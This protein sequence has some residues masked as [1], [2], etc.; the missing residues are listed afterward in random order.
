[1]P[2]VTLRLPVRSV[3]LPATRIRVTTAAALVGTLLAA[4]VAS[5][6]LAAD[7]PDPAVV[8]DLGSRAL[9]GSDVSFD[10]TFDNASASETGYGPYVDLRLPLGA[11]GDDGLTFAGATYLGAPVSAIRL[12]ADGSGC[13]SHPLA[14]DT[15]GQA[16]AVCGM[17][18]GQSFVVLRLPFGSYT[19]DQP[20]ARVVVSAT[21]SPLADLG[22]ALAVE[23]SGGFQFGA[24][25]ITDPATDPSIT[26]PVTTA[27]VTPTVF[28]LT[29][30]Y[31]GPEGE[32][33]TGPNYP[34]RYTI[35]AD[36]AP[37]QVI[38]GL[39]L[40]D[41][42]PG[43]IQFDSFDGSTPASTAVSTPDTAIPGGV[44]T[45]DFATV[46]GGAGIDAELAFGFHVPLRDAGAGAV[47]DPDSGSA[48]TSTDAA[49]ASGTWT[50]LDPRDPQLTVTVGPETHTL[51]DRSIAIQKSVAIAPG[52]DLAPTGVINPGDTLAWT[53][54]LQISDLFAFDGVSVFDRLADGTR[55]DGSFA[56]LLAVD[57]N[58]FDSPSAAFDPANLAVGPVEAGGVTPI[59]FDISAELR[60]R[61]ESGLLIGGCVD[62]AGGSATPDCGSYNDGPTTATITFRSIVQETYVDGT[63]PVV[64]GDDLGNVTSV[65]ASVL[66]TG[67]LTPT[68]DVTGDG[69]T[70]AA[71]PGSSASVSIPRGTLT[72]S[73]YAINGNTAVPSP[74]HLS[75]GDTVTYRLTQTFPNSRTADFQVIDYL[76]LPVLAATEISGF[77]PTTS[78][79]APPAGTAKYGPA[80]T[81]HLLAGA[82]TPVV[83]TSAGA[84][85]VTFTY[86]DYA[87]AAPGAASVADLLLTVTATTDPFSDG[88]SLANLARSITKNSAGQEA[89]SDGIVEI[90]LDQPSLGRTTGKLTKGVVA[91]SRA[92]AVYTPATAAPRTF[93]VPPG[94]SC[95]AWSGGP[96]TSA[97]LSTTP[98]N[99]DVAGLDAGDLAR[100]AFRVEN[101][102]HA[103]AYDAVFRD[104]LPAGFV[105][106]AG[107]IDLCV[108]RGNGVPLSV[109]NVGGGAGL[110]D[111]GI[112]VNGFLGTPAALAGLDADDVL[113]PSG[114]NVIII[115]FTLEVAPTAR[116]AAILE[117]TM[118]LD[119][120]S[121]AP[122]APNH[123]AAPVTNTATTTLRTIAVAKD[124][125]NSDQAHTTLPA[126]AIGE[127]VTYRV[128]VTVP[129][130][131]T[132][133]ATLTDALPAGL[134]FVGCDG[135]TASSGA[136]VTSLAGGFAAAC[137]PALNPTVLPT[138]GAGGGRTAT[139][140][141][142]TLSNTDRDNDTPETLTFEYRASVINAAANVRGTTLLNAA[143]LAWNDGT[144]NRSVT[145]AADA[146]RV[147]EPR[148]APDKT[149][150]PIAGDAGDTLT[151]QIVVT[152]P[153]AAPDGA[154][155]SRRHSSTRSRPD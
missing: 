17:D 102:G 31:S 15:S 74:A 42:L 83:S 124:V 148:I 128:V 97:L 18:P 116:P 69:G 34:R 32:T 60:D 58:G 68:G 138:T 14:V 20:A 119:G 153:A 113:N 118:S 134:A 92:D 100:F 76:P 56:P 96:I 44:L 36:I 73:I 93:N 80:D 111:Q 126:V 75:P 144:A 30:T 27:N 46:T 53:L 139:F 25:A 78:A 137:N 54:N 23:A 112:L 95:P 152:N 3:Q 123:L 91:T 33:A 103:D 108:T 43:S 12:T 131:T 50:P 21:L 57:G 64:E 125:I 62:P 145:D 77:D 6:A 86:G 141:L 101:L 117:N 106:P 40:T 132:G 133:P 66:D 10:V 135:I 82:P 24:T 85:S 48:A 127:V 9:I 41:T 51:V 151:Y 45:R 149:V 8:L 129:E 11:D 47:I 70:A 98:I 122:G 109:A 136:L 115:T 26:G 155:P 5:G 130:G 150:S 1:M 81:F 90:T 114:S 61:G 140:S 59:T 67:N 142:G 39:Q 63:T 72:K 107:G 65:T 120:Y 55:V 88:L 110:L 147:V 104:D 7:P 84:N 19:P 52:G 99:S 37:G 16:V 154:T 121:S 87:L 2:V 79:A 13:V 35:A 146:V 89:T 29:K 38:T 4:T 28:T 94:G 143:T 49:S 22:T 71:I 105:V